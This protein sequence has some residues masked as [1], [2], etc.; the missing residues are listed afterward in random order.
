[1]SP[2]VIGSAASH[3]RAWAR[4]QPGASGSRRPNR[5]A[6]PGGTE[7]LRQQ[8]TPYDRFRG[9]DYWMTDHGYDL[10]F[11]YFLTTAN[12]A[13]SWTVGLQDHPCQPG[14]LDTRMLLSCVATRT[15]GTQLSA[16]VARQE[17]DRRAWTGWPSCCESSQQRQRWRCSTTLERHRGGVPS[18]A[19][20]S[21]P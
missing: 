11:G 1:M 17:A 19:S 9:D 14:F 13:P 12:S 20:R 10:S 3:F 4:P 6:L 2:V 16:N 8:A 7:Q 18:S 15:S 5:G 21:P